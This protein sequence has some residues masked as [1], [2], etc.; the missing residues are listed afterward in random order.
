MRSALLPRR[1]H[2]LVCAAALLTC[3]PAVLVAA[4]RAPGFDPS[5]FAIEGATVVVEPGRVIADDLV[6]AA[7]EQR[8]ERRRFRR[9]VR[10]GFADR[11]FGRLGFADPPQVND[12]GKPGIGLGAEVVDC[13]AVG[14][15]GLIEQAPAR[16]GQLPVR[17]SRA[18]CASSAKAT[19]QGSL[20]CRAT[21]RVSWKTSARQVGPS[22][23]AYK[24]ARC[25]VRG[26][27]SW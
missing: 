8:P 21:T 18:S 3:L 11:R 27:G 2:S 16:V 17:S 25:C 6:T 10:L 4:D 15:L 26:G 7:K 9:N 13:L 12:V 22:A 1:L 19:I 5:T 24:M 23:A 20:C 14:G